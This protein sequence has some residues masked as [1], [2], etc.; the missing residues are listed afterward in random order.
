MAYVQFDDS[1]TRLLFTIRNE[2]TGAVLYDGTAGSLDVDRSFT[3]TTLTLNGV[4]GLN[5]AKAKN[6][7][8]TLADYHKE[9]GEIWE[10]AFKAAVAAMTAA[11]AEAS[12]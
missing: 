7:S 8:K 9:Y 10:A 12:K 1:A 11:G 5:E 6:D 4:A 2:K 3:R